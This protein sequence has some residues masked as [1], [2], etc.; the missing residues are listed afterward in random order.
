M[1]RDPRLGNKGVI[2]TASKISDSFH[3]SGERRLYLRFTSPHEVGESLDAFINK[4]RR[5][6]VSGRWCFAGPLHPDSLQKMPGATVVIQRFIKEFDPERVRI[7]VLWPSHNPDEDGAF[8]ADVIENLLD[9]LQGIDE[10]VETV[11]VDGR[12]RWKNGL[13]LADFFD[14]A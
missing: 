8:G 11:C 13:V 14:F 6:M 12:Q 3:L 5:K 1:F 7:V 9:D 10:R 2:P 4:T